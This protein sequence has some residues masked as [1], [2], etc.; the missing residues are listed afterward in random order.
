[1]IQNTP[2]IQKYI[3]TN[4]KLSN[5]YEHFK[6]PYFQNCKV[7][8]NQ[9]F[10]MIFMVLLI[11]CIFCTFILLLL[12]CRTPRICSPERI[13]TRTALCSFL[14]VVRNCWA[15]RHRRA[16]AQRVAAQRIAAVFCSKS[17]RSSKMF[18][19]FCSKSSNMKNGRTMLK[20]KKVWNQFNKRSH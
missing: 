15:P 12:P 1:M 16:A 14:P 11:F 17:S 3:A 20:N 10:M 13:Q 8:N 18:S 2:T 5:I 19:V 9:R 4:L 6:N 7:W